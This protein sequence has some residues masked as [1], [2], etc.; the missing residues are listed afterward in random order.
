MLFSC[1]DPCV[2]ETLYHLCN[3]YIHSPSLFSW[4]PCWT[5]DKA[6][7]NYEIR[8]VRAL[9]PWQ[10]L[11]LLF[12]LSAAV[13]ISLYIA[14]EPSVLFFFPQKFIIMS[15]YELS[16]PVKCQSHGLCLHSAFS[17]LLTPQTQTLP[18]IHEL[19]TEAA[20][21]RLHQL[22]LLICTAGCLSFWLICIC[23]VLGLFLCL[24]SQREG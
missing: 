19:M 3:F 6:H 18:H 12:H 9:S 17:R 22:Q 14:P 5:D 2:Y 15:L 11:S 1:F 24:Y 21:E 7:W 13:Y 23:L 20:V 4:W 10:T 8:L 16:V